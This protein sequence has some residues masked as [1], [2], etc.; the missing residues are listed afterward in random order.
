MGGSEWAGSVRLGSCSWKE[1]A[2]RDII[3]TSP[4]HLGSHVVFKAK[5]ISLHPSWSMF[6]GLSSILQHIKSLSPFTQ[7]C[8]AYAFVKSVLYLSFML[9]PQEAACAIMRA[10]RIQHGAQHFFLAAG[11]PLN[12][13]VDR[14]WVNGL[15]DDLGQL[16]VLLL[17]QVG[18]EHAL[19]SIRIFNGLNDCTNTSADTDMTRGFALLGLRLF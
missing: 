15:M 11:N 5:S 19:R 2:L 17:L 1:L 3:V 10:R 7:L 8:A 12:V 13:V 18:L 16:H 14:P 9:A 4:E 6:K